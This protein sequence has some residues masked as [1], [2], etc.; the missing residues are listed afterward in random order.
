MEY[1]P[2]SSDSNQQ[3][4]VAGYWQAGNRKIEGNHPIAGERDRAKRWNN[5]KLVLNRRPK[6]RTAQVERPSFERG[7]A[8]SRRIQIKVWVTAQIF[9]RAGTATKLQRGST[10]TTVWHSRLSPSI[11]K[12]AGLKRPHHQTSAGEW[13]HFQA[14]H[15]GDQSTPEAYINCWRMFRRVKRF[16]LKD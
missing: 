9:N 6:R 5:K 7:T 3:G 12:S 11:D 2:P 8:G 13:Y 16:A 15:R 1:C 14:V 4:I 10:P